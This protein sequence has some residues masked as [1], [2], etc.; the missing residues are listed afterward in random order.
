MMMTLIIEEIDNG[1]FIFI[2]ESFVHNYAF[3]IFIKFV[4][5]ILTNYDILSI[6]IA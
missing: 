4:L 1:L 5:E 3:N 6:W 2:D